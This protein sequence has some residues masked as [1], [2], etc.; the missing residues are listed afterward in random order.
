MHNSTQWLLFLVRFELCIKR[1][2]NMRTGHYQEDCEE[3]ITW[4]KKFPN[5][6]IPGLKA[7]FE[8]RRWPEIE[9]EEEEEKN[10]VLEYAVTFFSDEEGCCLSLPEDPMDDIFFADTKCEIEKIADE[11]AVKLQNAKKGQVWG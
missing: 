1:R 11:I 10:E 8:E 7:V 5:A 6:L 3:D 4:E 2:K 9:E